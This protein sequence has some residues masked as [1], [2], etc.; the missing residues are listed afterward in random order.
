[1]KALTKARARRLCDRLTRDDERL[2][3][4]ERDLRRALLK[5]E[6]PVTAV[7]DRDERI[8]SARLVVEDALFRMESLRGTR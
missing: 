1:V 6:E 3:D 2:D 8:V 5:L 4:A 7:R